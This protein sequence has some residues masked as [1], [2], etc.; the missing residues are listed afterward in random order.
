VH[1]NTQPKF[2]KVRPVPFS[3]R[4][5][6]EQEL[7]ELQDKGII[8]PVQFSSWGIP[9]VPVLKKNGKI[10]ICGDYKLITKPGSTN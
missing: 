5:K 9:V 8:S 10:R 4:Q 6:V 2:Y 3:V 1:D 7:Q